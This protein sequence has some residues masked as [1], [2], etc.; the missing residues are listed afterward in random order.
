MRRLGRGY[1]QG[2]A[3]V[4]RGP[5]SI[6]RDDETMVVACGTDHVGMV[7]LYG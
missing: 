4:D 3:T 6:R 5:A 1:M 2:S 7:D